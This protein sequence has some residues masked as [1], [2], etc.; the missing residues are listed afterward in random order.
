MK[1]QFDIESLRNTSNLDF[2][3][4]FSNE[5]GMCKTTVDLIMK[6][7]SL[8]YN[9]LDRN[10]FAKLY[11]QI[12]NL[13]DKEFSRK[14]V[15]DLVFRVFNHNHDNY[16]TMREFMIGMAVSTCGSVKHKVE[17]AFSLYDGNNHGWLTK[18]EIK[19]GLRE[20][21]NLIGVNNIDECISGYIDESIRSME[22]GT[23]GK[24]S[25]GRL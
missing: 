10:E 17:Y 21:F 14:Q 24:I 6:E 9:R 1:R 5:I 7:F 11:C 16:L 22:V 2:E 15:S 18:N 8:K 19:A 12:H 20:I 23:G 4:F 25:K 13:D 3:S